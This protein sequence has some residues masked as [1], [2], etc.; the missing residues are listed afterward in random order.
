MSNN[1]YKVKETEYELKGEILLKYKNLKK[2]IENY[3]DLIRPFTLLAPIIVSSSIMISSFFYNKENTDFFTFSLTLIVPASFALAILNAASNTLNQVTDIKSDKISKPY[4]P[5]PQGLVSINNA[6]SVSMIL[7]IGAISIS[8]FINPMF[9][10][11]V[12]LIVL[13]TVTYSLPPRFK[14]FLF[15]NQIWI[16]IPRGLLGILASW[17]VFG[18]VLQP[19][20]IS[21]GII[22]M[23][24]LIGGSIT[25]DIS[26]CDADKKTGTKTLINTF[27]IKRAGLIALPL[28]IFPFAYIPIL[29]DLGFLHSNLWFLTFLVFP[30]LI[31]FLLMIR[32]NNKGKFF[33]N[34]LSWTVMYVT[35]FIFA[36]CFSFLTIISSF[37][38]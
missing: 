14:D 9:C 10:F 22:A 8:L 16:G 31:I 26:D 6:L 34:T 1:P 2:Q 15:I 19:L 30:S 25:K 18:N 12:L 38:G 20:P 11:L 37:S 5:I 17:S 13:F 3:I 35:Y 7:Y 29:I 23:L 36:S 24:F 32:D 28:M 27:G 33:E 4:R 21:I